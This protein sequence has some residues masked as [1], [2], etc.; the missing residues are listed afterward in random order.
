MEAYQAF[1]DLEGMK[2]LTRG[3]VQAAALRH[4][5]LSWQE[6]MP[7]LLVS[8][9]FSADPDEAFVCTCSCVLLPLGCSGER[10]A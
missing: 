10:K 2:E 3:F 5:F 6:E 7:F 8:S 1:T 9:L 4:A